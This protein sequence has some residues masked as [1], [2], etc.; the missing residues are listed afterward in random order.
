MLRFGFVVL[1]LWEGRV[2][3]FRHVGVQE[4]F[5][6]G[7]EISLLFYPGVVLAFD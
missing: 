7:T 5:S 3:G 6:L 1:L 4:G 2:L